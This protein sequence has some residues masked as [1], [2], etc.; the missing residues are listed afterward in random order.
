MGKEVY[1][2]QSAGWLVNGKP[3]SEWNIM[4]EFMRYNTHEELDDMDDF[5]QPTGWRITN[6]GILKAQQ[7][8]Y[9]IKIDGTII[10][11]ATDLT[12][13]LTKIDQTLTAK[14]EAYQKACNE[15]QQQEKEKQDI[16]N[17]ANK[18]FQD[19]FKEL[20]NEFSVQLD[21]Q[22][23]PKF[24]STIETLRG[25]GDGQYVPHFERGM[26][27]QFEIIHYDTS[28]YDW[29]MWGI[30]VRPTDKEAFL[31]YIADWKE[32]TALEMKLQSQK[33]QQERQVI[34]QKQKEEKEL[35]EQE[36]KT[37]IEVKSQELSSKTKPQLL[38]EYPDLLKKGIIKKSWSKI[39]L[40]NKIATKL[41]EPIPIGTQDGKI[42]GNVLKQSKKTQKEDYE[43]RPDYGEMY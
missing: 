2:S 31:Q 41:T 12:D 25:G 5:D 38:S 1:L 4:K 20:T 26:I 21:F 10:P 8:G 24:D 35:K 7:L 18:K 16:I 19:R 37:Q 28:M 3:F 14:K 6:E 34:E 15:K 23:T 43:D 30:R 29:D 36:R 27:G 22:Q 40:V 17:E 32:K 11:K 42:M 9:S 13:L 33:Y 39:E